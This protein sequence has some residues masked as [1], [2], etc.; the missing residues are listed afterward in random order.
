MTETP[1]NAPPTEQKAEPTLDDHVEQGKRAYALRQFE[2]AV[3]E[4]ATALELVYVHS[5][6]SRHDMISD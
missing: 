5:N 6:A 2:K 1:E 4:Y 3:E